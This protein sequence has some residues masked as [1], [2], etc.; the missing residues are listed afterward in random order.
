MLAKLLEQGGT[1]GET[2]EIA[3]TK[4][5][6]LIGRGSDCDL[7]LHST[8]VSRHHC[9]LR[10][11]GGEAVLVD[12]GSAN[13][14]FVNGLRVR[15]Q[16]ALAHGTEIALGD[17]RFLLNMGGQSGIDWGS[18]TGGAETAKTCRL[19]NIAREL[20]EPGPKKDESHPPGEAGGLTGM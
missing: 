10:I 13:G 19:D 3:I 7:R 17:F 8:A 2:R 4:D 16:Q 15:S 9:L 5:E 14:T 18:K 12:L 6:F 20:L 1:G 11:R